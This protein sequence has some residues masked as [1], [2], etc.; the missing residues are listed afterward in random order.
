MPIQGYIKIEQ[1]KDEISV[2]YAITSFN[3][4]IY[5]SFMINNSRGPRYLFKYK[6][7]FNCIVLGQSLNVLGRFIFYQK[8]FPIST[9]GQSLFKQ[10]N[11][12]N[13]RT[14]QLNFTMKENEH[15]ITLK[16]GNFCIVC[17]V[18]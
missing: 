14:M 10:I 18:F 4:M 17:N 11:F 2:H 6:S 1:L 8:Y 12:E 13:I 7:E 16:I 9:V 15:Y 3:L 5:F